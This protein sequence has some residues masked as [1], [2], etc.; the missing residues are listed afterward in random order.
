M[1]RKRVESI[2]KQLGWTVISMNKHIKC[3]DQNNN[4]RIISHTLVKKCADNP[5][6]FNDSASNKT[7]WLKNKNIIKV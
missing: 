2:L 3:K 6:F 7:R 5:R 4:I 1:Q